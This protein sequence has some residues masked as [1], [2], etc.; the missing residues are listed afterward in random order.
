MS[1]VVAIVEGETEQT[2]VRDQLAAHLALSGTTIW[3]VLPGRHRNRGGVKRWVVAKADIIRTLREKRYCTTMFDYYAMPG[4]W[5]GRA[6]SKTLPWQER[7][8]HVQTKMLADIAAEMGQ[9]FN[10]KVF[11]PYVQLHEFEALT[12]ADVEKLASVTAAL[13]NRS[14]DGH[15]QKFEQIVKEAGHPEA[16]NDNYETCPSRR[17]AAIEPGY[18]KRVHGPI[19]TGRIGL[20]TLREK[21]DHFAAW[22]T[23][24]E[25]LNVGA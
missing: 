20:A 23:R 17:I 6:S 2:F 22:V 10:P 4:D 19:T 21:C 8:D 11:L 12:F 1:E 9:S 25:Q 24:L 14:V 7:A 13:Q 5:P 16:I 15:R 3:A 18:R